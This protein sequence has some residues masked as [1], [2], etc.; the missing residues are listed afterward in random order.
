MIGVSE[1]FKNA[2]RQPVKTIRA[3]I[4]VGEQVYSSAD[5]LMSLTKEDTGFY[6]GVATKSLSFKLLGTDYDLLNELATV[7]LELLT[8]EQENIWEECNLGLF[9]VYSQASDLDKGTTTFQAYD[10]IGIMGKQKYGAGDLQ[11]ESSV[12]NLVS[13]L[14]LRFNLSYQPIDLVKGNYV[15]SEDLYAKISEITHRD[16][17]AEIAGAT[18]SLAMVS[19]NTLR[20]RQL[21]ETSLETLTYSNLRKVKLEPKYG[22]VNSIVLARTPQEDNIAETD[23]ESVTEHG[24]TEIKLANNEILDDDRQELILPILNAADGLKF[25]PFEATTEGHGWYEIGDRLTIT[26]G[27][28]SWDVIVTSISLTIGSTGIKETLKSVAPTETKTNYALA[29]N[30]MKSVFNTEIKVDKQNQ[31]IENIVSRQDTIESQEAEHYSQIIQNI[32][33]ITTTIKETGGANL[34]YNS[35]GY[36]VNNT[37]TLIDWLTTGSTISVTSPESISYGAISG[38][39]V[40]ILPSSKITQRVTVDGSGEQKYSLSILVK[41]AATGTATISLKNELDTFVIMIPANESVLWKRYEL[42]GF[43]ASMNYFDVEIATDSDVTDFAYTD[44]MLAIGSSTIPW[45]QASGE[46]L[47]TQVA[48]TRNGMKV[49][50]S[51]YAGDYVQITPLEFAGFSTA[52]GIEEKV[53]SLNRD[54]TEVQKLQAEKQ[55]TMPPFKIIPITSG[56]RAGWSFVKMENK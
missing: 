43:S 22:P 13:Q 49:R 42:V 20:L 19:G 30:S 6:F 27:T 15:I 47:N 28:N 35:V 52:S 31:K 1:T 3:S 29:G 41:K 17:L 11:F 23:N 53:F 44:L 7:S 48:I 56:A 46:T 32:E 34:V 10:P 54:T 40:T 4:T 18:A 9:R 21:G 55:I 12:S 14:A 45:V 24:L 33:S 37:G 51:V 8:D 36:D 38:N 5:V 16:I 50:S 39:Q 2:A 26:D 25:Y